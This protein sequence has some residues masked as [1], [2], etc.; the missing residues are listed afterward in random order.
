MPKNH[1]KHRLT[2]P[3]TCGNARCL[4]LLMICKWLNNIITKVGCCG[5]AVRGGMKSYYKQF[6]LVEI[7]STSYNS[8]RIEIVEKWRSE[9]PI[10]FEFIPKAFQGITH[11]ISS[12][13]SRKFRGKLQDKDGKTD[14]YG[15]FRPTDEVISCWKRT[16]EVCGKL[17]KPFLS[18][19]GFNS[20]LLVALSR[21]LLHSC[22]LW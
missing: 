18:H 17:M 22:Q 8:P 1:L 20:S 5:F 11:P 4:R 21:R 3:R 9:A 7:Q 13:T 2:R 12:P 14:Y 6:G 19:Q 15:F 10:D 16:I